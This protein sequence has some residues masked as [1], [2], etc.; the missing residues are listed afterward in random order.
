MLF[1]FEFLVLAFAT[2]HALPVDAQRPDE[3]R[4]ATLSGKRPAKGTNN[5]WYRHTSSDTVF[6][7]VHG[8][9]SDSRQ[10]W[11]F[12]NKKDSLE[13]VYWPELLA[14][15]ARFGSPDIYLGGYHTALHQGRY[16]V[17]Q[18][19]IE[20]KAALD[21]PDFDG[22]RVLDKRN[23]IFIA[24]STGGL[25]ARYLL[26][27]NPT[28]FKGKNVGLFMLAA[29]SL[30]SQ[31]ANRAGKVI[32]FYRNKMAEELQVD[33][34][35]M[36]Q[37]DSDFR[38]L[39]Q[40]KT[41]WIAGS[42][43]CESHF[44]VSGGLFAFFRDRSVVVDARSC[45]AYFTAPPKIIFD[46]DHYSI[47]KPSGF[48]SDQHKYLLDF[49]TS[50]FAAMQRR[51][52]TESRKSLTVSVEVT[53]TLLLDSLREERPQPFHFKASSCGDTTISSFYPVSQGW[54]LT[55]ATGAKVMTSLA[56][57]NKTSVRGTQPSDT[58]VTVIVDIRAGKDSAGG[59]QPGE[60]AYEVGLLEVQLISR[61]LASSTRSGVVDPDAPYFSFQYPL[62]ELRAAQSIRWKY[63]ARVDGFIGYDR[64]RID[65][66]D[67]HPDDPTDG[68]VSSISVGGMVRLDA[69]GAFL[70][71]AISH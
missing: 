15:D 70:K 30:G 6:V 17:V 42:E 29:P 58:G 27:H 32:D 50:D 67:E 41:L 1:R 65:L 24:H 63:A 68:L 22:H 57:G 13:S 55:N 5:L 38:N 3:L 18:A 33:D 43:L 10:G 71:R 40:E 23:I 7:F 52:A 9:L 51:T 20:L 62:S 19:A 2:A 37:L 44:V 28:L 48:G 26:V 56:V 64:L 46:S 60:L 8:I 31:W 54:R 45:A 35:R 39:L 12:E 34:P 53:P 59:C 21:R 66:S 61:T 14:Q 16:D 47:V 25:V 4:T 36:D 49:I 11:F 69:A